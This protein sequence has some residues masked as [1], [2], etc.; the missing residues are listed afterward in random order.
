MQSSQFSI[1]D[2]HCTANSTVAALRKELE[3]IRNDW[4]MH[5]FINTC[6]FPQTHMRVSRNTYACFHKHI[7]VL[8]YI[9]A[10]FHTCIPVSY[11]HACINTHMHVSIQACTFPHTNAC[12]H[13]YMR[14]SMHTCTF[15]YK[16]AR[17][18][19]HMRVFIHTCVFPCTH[20]F[21][22]HVCGAHATDCYILLDTLAIYIHGLSCTARTLQQ[23]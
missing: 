1:Q 11:I 16:H 14:V 10:H 4:Y 18:L 13:T 15:L 7:C 17:F 9:Y 5:V 8:P 23:R 3:H 6:V 19:T 22:P 20:A 12:F 21:Y 2:R